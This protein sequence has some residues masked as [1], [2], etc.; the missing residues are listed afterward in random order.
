VVLSACPNQHFSSFAYSTSYTAQIT[1]PHTRKNLLANGAATPD[2]VIAVLTFFL[3]HVITK[4]SVNKISFFGTY[5]QVR[6]LLE[7]RFLHPSTLHSFAARFV[8]RVLPEK[9]PL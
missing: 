8:L 4:Q 1:T 6:W 7:H 3:G 5:T 9:L 2:H